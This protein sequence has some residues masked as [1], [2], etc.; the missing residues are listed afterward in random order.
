MMISGHESPSPGREGIADPRTEA[1]GEPWTG[2]SPTF[3]L[4]LGY[5]PHVSGGGNE[6]RAR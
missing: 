4:R 1:A 5:A 6:D 3:A 2:D